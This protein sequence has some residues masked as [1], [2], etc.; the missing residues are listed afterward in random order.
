MTAHHRTFPNP[1]SFKNEPAAMLFR[2]SFFHF[3]KWQAYYFV[4]YPATTHFV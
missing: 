4:F 2:S 1:K 3:Y